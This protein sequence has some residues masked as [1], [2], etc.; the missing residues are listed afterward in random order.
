MSVCHIPGDYW[1]TRRSAWFLPCELSIFLFAV[2]YLVQNI[3]KQ[4]EYCVP[5][6]GFPNHLFLFSSRMVLGMSLATVVL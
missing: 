3:L 1:V 5:F 4:S 2:M 6:Y